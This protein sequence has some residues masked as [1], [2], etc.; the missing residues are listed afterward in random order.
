MNRR[1][2]LIPEID[3]AFIYSFKDRMVQPF[4][5]A[6]HFTISYTSLSQVLGPKMTRSLL[7]KVVRL[8][9]HQQTDQ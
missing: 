7:R 3:K 6:S 4:L 9:N 8:D 5:L 1:L 2:Y